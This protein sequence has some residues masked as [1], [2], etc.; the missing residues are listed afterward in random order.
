MSKVN[1]GF[2]QRWLTWDVFR[3]EL[4]CK[5]IVLSVSPSSLFMYGINLCGSKSQNVKLVGIPSI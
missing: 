3:R 1:I 5:I 2:D 4:G